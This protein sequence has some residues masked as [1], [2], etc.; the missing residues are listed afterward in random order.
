MNTLFLSYRRGDSPDTVTLIHDRLAA[1]FR[2]WTIFYDHKSIPP[3]EPFPEVLRRN[4][5]TAD[6]VL[7]IIGPR[8][9]ETLHERTS[10]PGV[11]RVREEVR[12]ALAAGHS[13]LPVT[14]GGTRMPT[15]ADLT[16]FPDICRLT[17]L[18]GLQVR[19][20][21][22]HEADIAQL[23]TAI[24]RLGPGEGPGTV[25]GGT[26]KLIREVGAGGMGVVFLAEQAHP[27][28]EVAV[29][30]VKPGM[31]SR[32]VLA[33]FEAERQALGL[34]THPNIARA[35]DAGT[36]PGGR[37]Y[38]VME[39]VPGV[40][41]TRFC[42]EHRLALA[43]RLTLFR[44]VCDAL[45]HAHQKGIIHRD[46]KPSNVLVE[47]AG[48][49]PVPKVID[50][51]LAKALGGRLTDRTLYTDFRAFVGT[52]EYAS[53]EQVSGAADVDTRADV[54]ALGALLYEM[55]CGSPPFAADELE[56]AGVAEA[57]RLVR[58]S[59]P[60]RLSARLSSSA[61]LRELA[62]KRKTD[63]ARLVREVRGELDWIV[64]KSLDKERDRR[65]STAAALADDITRFLNHEP[66]SAGRPSTAHRLRKFVRRNRGPVAAAG[67]VFAALVLGVAGTTFGLL[68]AYDAE[69]AALEAAGAARQARDEQAAAADDARR[70]WA[71][72][73]VEVQNANSVTGYLVDLFKVSDPEKARGRTVTARELLDRNAD[74]IERELKDR[75]L[76]QARLMDALGI[77][78]RNLG[79][80][81]RAQQLIEE[82]L[83]IRERGLGPGH[84]DV[85]ATAHNLAELWLAK[86]DEARATLRFRQALDIRRKVFGDRHPDVAQTLAGL[87]AA[88]ASGGRYAE[89]KKNYEQA[90]QLWK[91]L[92]GENHPAYV[93][94]LEGLARVYTATG[95]YV[96][97]APLLRQVVEFHK[98][99][100]GEDHPR[101]A[102]SLHT[103]G[104]LYR[105]MGDLARA[106]PLLRAVADLDLKVFGPAH[107]TTAASLNDLGLLYHDLGNFPEARDKLTE[108]AAIRKAVFGEDSVTHASSLYFLGCLEQA[109][110]NPEKAV[111]YLLET[112][113][114]RE[115][116]LTRE[117]R[118]TAAALQRLGT[119]YLDLK[120]GPGLGQSE[121]HLSEAV[122]VYRS[123]LGDGHPETGR[124]I[125]ELGALYYATGD[126]P[127]ATSLLREALGISIR[128]LR[129]AA[130]VQSERQQLAM[131][132][133]A[134]GQFDAYLALVVAAGP[135]PETAYP[136]FLAWKGAVS[137]RKSQ[138]RLARDR[139]EIAVLQDELERVTG[140]LAALAYSDRPGSRTMRV[141]ELEALAERRDR[142]EMD[143]ARLAF[144]AGGL[145]LP[146]PDVRQ[147][148]AALP[149]DVALVDLFEYAPPSA[150]GVNKPAG[151]KVTRKVAAFV[152]RRE[153]ITLVDLGPAERIDE[154]LAVRRAGMRPDSKPQPSGDRLR[155]LVWAPLEAHLHGASVLLVSP[156]GVTHDIPWLALPGRRPG[157]YLIEETSVVVAP[158]PQLLPGL[159]GPD[160]PPRPAD[161][162]LLLV[163]D[164]DYGSGEKTFRFPRLPGTQEEI[165][166]ARELF[167][168]GK[169]TGRMVILT[170]LD[171][172]KAAVR[173]EL[174]LHTW[175]HLSTHGFSARIDPRE[176]TPSL[177]AQSRGIGVD[178]VPNLIFDPAMLAG[179]ALS[180]ANRTRLSGEEVGILTALE[181][182]EMDLR[183]V[184]LVVLSACETSSG[185][186][187][188][189]EGV[190]GLHRAFQTAGA[191]TVI[192]ASG[193]IND[194]ATT[195]LMK[196]MYASLRNGLPRGA[197][198]RR[199]QLSMLEEA[200]QAA[201]DDRRRNYNHAYYWSQ[202]MLFGDWR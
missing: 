16:D 79:Q 35:L 150:S 70:A 141:S 99:H 106:E 154:A 112:L 92:L 151:Q 15:I 13:V 201:G 78:Y 57:R 168:Q 194:D 56:R 24:E 127:K 153:S 163:G 131:A 34:M 120:D 4:V 37:P 63:P 195:E 190:Y 52:L 172:T 76:L 135:P 23:L 33:R 48:G 124:A 82:A 107:P 55:L 44:Q 11:D 170:G 166:M 148:Q 97:A 28:R 5:T 149:A 60:P 67:L 128:T 179:L 8:W 94:G 115:R 133:K 72:A 167:S 160:R 144:G 62:E 143:M 129:S 188:G 142:L 146:E 66:V 29:K 198:L 14:V 134:R 90:I 75:P 109:A 84:P 165:K 77:V 183:R 73:E 41:I 161:A 6:I 177:R 169:R 18:N 155:E 152:V 36:T 121:R 2:H 26:Y 173:R 59:D 193:L 86:G 200:R 85:A 93:T 69:R 140:Q 130:R 189:A 113:R 50:F 38:F 199:A 187:I 95:E 43:D 191:R 117:H 87:A 65:Y 58:E 89:A 9:L 10:Q 185:K 184:E 171:A 21:P 145:D 91:D 116:A 20:D 31:D 119:V 181:V 136:Y 1:R 96:S 71:K 132:R 49:Q 182:A 125:H 192:A 19:P 156:D 105:E 114:V 196:R 102:A 12:L 101:Y 157:T 118:D 74:R 27:R 104:N 47:G 178:E 81:D 139:P 17:E 174:P 61:G 186:V 51:G 158:V 68:R 54:Y 83:A 45:Q 108:A 88:E 122:R 100:H 202:F 22:D 32:E 3:G 42:D 164:L 175:V 111:W 159:L 103:L 30:L 138:L 180:G 147:L 137:A 123:V 7:V 110:G 126:Y 40:A 162:S 98:K 197:A 25:L 176:I 39:Y 64:A 53:P 46:V 80:Y